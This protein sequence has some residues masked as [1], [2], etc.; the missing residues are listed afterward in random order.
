MMKSIF[1]L[2]LLV[3]EAAAAASCVD[4][5]NDCLQKTEQNDVGKRELPP[6]VPPKLSGDDEDYLDE[7]DLPSESDHD[8]ARP[9]VRISSL[10]LPLRKMIGL[11]DEEL[12][13]SIKSSIG[14]EIKRSIG[15]L[16][17]GR[18]NQHNNKFKVKRPFKFKQD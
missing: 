12:D 7:R 9:R 15:M 14:D 10:L 2:T 8:R 18:M 13:G 6:L 4:D 17:M 5:E 1:V 3:F 16:R 11:M